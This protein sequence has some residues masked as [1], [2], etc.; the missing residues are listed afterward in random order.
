MASRSVCHDLPNQP[1]TLWRFGVVGDLSDG[2]L[3]QRFLTA[4]DGADQAA[5]TALVERHGPMVLGVCRQVLGNAQDAQDAFQAT[6]LVLARKAGSVRKADS[7]AGWLH[8]VARRVAIQAKAEAARRRVYERRGAAMKAV[9]LERQEGSPEGWPELHE[10]IARL[11]ERYREPVVLCYLEGLTTEEAAL[12]IGCPQ[13]TI[14]SRLSRARE[15][16]RG[17]LERRGLASPTTF[18]ATGLKPRPMEALPAGSLDTTVRAAIGFAGG[19]TSGAGL[20]SASATILAKGVLRTMAISKLK[21]LVAMALACGFAWGGVRTFGQLGG[22][23]DSQEP[24]RAVPGTDERQDALSRAVDKLQSDLDESARRTAK[25]QREL[26]DIRA[27]LKAQPASQQPSAAAESVMR[28]AAAL[29]R[30][31]RQFSRH[32]PYRSQIYMLDLVEGGITL[33]A[34]EPAPGH[35]LCGMPTWSH[36]GSRILFEAGRGEEWPRARLWAIEVR[37]ARPNYT[38]LGEGNAPTFSPDDQRIAFLLHAGVESGAGGGLFMMRADGSERHQVGDFGVPYWSP[39]GRQLLINGY[40][41]PT[42]PALLDLETKDEGIIKVPGHRIFSWPSWVAPGM[43][44]S[45][46]AP[47]DRYEGDSIALLDV[48]QPAEAKIIELLWKRDADLDVIPRWPVFR[49]GT[50]QCFFAGEEPRKEGEGPGK[51]ALYSVQRGAS[52]RAR[53]MGIVA[54]Q[55]AP[56]TGGSGFGCLAFSP[57]GRYLLIDANGPLLEEP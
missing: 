37:D 56:G 42:K 54:Q 53:H 52:L 16:L 11:P 51:R 32:A 19:P 26:Q 4:R 20:A 17:Q 45:A 14:L 46:L 31:P 39:D 5:F 36:D 9:Q 25:M 2:Q 7:L 55:H 40:A 33:I 35:H 10:A 22:V 12:R 15:R 47:K 38:R 50:R 6:F 23:G 28:L 43:V 18:L 1:T 8:R 13:G 3:V 44:V 34:C 49:P 30:Y 21:I 27:R 57:D 48:H 29:K 24:S 41:L